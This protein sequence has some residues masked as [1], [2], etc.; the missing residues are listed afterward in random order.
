MEKIDRDTVNFVKTMSQAIVDCPEC[1]GTGIEKCI[2][3][4]GNEHENL[5]QY[6]SGSGVKEEGE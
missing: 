5:C 6:C 4:C 3:S 2:C 1:S